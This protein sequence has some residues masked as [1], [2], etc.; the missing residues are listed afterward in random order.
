[1]FLARAPGSD[2]R[3]YVVSALSFENDGVDSVLLEEMA[4]QESGRTSSD[5]NDLSTFS[6]LHSHPV[7]ASVDGTLLT[8][9]E[10]VTQDVLEWLACT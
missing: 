9:P 8:G 3:F 10:W 1:M 2:P 7:R 4:E 6:A 5:D